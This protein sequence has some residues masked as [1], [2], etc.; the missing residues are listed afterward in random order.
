MLYTMFEIRF[1]GW[2]LLELRAAPVSRMEAECCAQ[3]VP[4]GTGLLPAF[5]RDQ[6]CLFL[7]FRLKVVWCHN[8]AQW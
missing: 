7:G 1:L 6:E 5:T 4:A 2:F 8:A 3:D